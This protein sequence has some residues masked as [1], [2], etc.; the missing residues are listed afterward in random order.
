MNWRKATVAELQAENAL[1]VEDGNHGENRPRPNEFAEA[2]TAFIRGA[3]MDAGHLLFATASRI[4]D[5]ALTRVRK[6]IGKPGD[7]LLSHK[8]TV[9]KIAIAP[10]DCEPFVCSPQT[11]FWRVMDDAKI[12]QWYLFCF[13][14]SPLFTAQLASRKGETDMADYVSLT[15]QRT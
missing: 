2:G 1:L 13:L 14:R 4:N 8:G 12:D 11:T 6:G 9:G 15:T 5:V 10:L 3:D 7:V